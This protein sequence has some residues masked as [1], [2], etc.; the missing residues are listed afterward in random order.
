MP[1]EIYEVVAQAARYWFVFLMAMIVWRS[2]RW[3][4]KDRR[5][6]KKRLRLL[7]DAGYI[8]ELVVQAGNEAFPQGTVLPVPREGTL[9]YLRSCDLYL[10]VEGVAS[11]HLWFRY[12]DGDGL[13]VK[14][15][16]GRAF[17]VDGED[18]T[19]YRKHGFMAH[20]SRLKV[21]EAV[22]RLRMFAGFETTAHAHS[23]SG[24]T[25]PQ[26]GEGSETEGL[27][28]DA[29]AA[30][31]TAQQEALWQANQQW[32]QQMWMVAQAAATQAAAQAYMAAHPGGVHPGGAQPPQDE[33]VWDAEETDEAQWD[34]EMEALEGEQGGENGRDDTLPQPSRLFSPFEPLTEA[35][36]PQ[37]EEPVSQEI[38]FGSVGTF[39][40]PVEGGS[41]NWPYAPYPQSEVTFEQKGYTYPEYVEPTPSGED[42]DLTDAAAPPKSLYVE[43]DEAEKAKKLLWDKY[44]GGGHKR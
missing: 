29:A 14:A 41:E 24:L 1:S 23:G 4:A 26:E 3:L 22:L 20:G 34:E 13:M 2:Y 6:R 38:D 31:I 15:F 42:D 36:E 44:L 17:V 9:G 37:M 5:Q 7:P 43:P 18:I 8:G 28:G 27:T 16:S 10:P 19:G 12:E 35:Q 30:A 11:R 40:P 21:G 39:Y 32:Q 25:G 33:Y